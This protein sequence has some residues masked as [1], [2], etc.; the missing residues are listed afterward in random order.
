MASRVGSSGCGAQVKKALRTP[1]SSA[2]A[3][4]Q[5]QVVCYERNASYISA[6]TTAIFSTKISD[7]LAEADF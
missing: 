7:Q 1:N 2:S 5:G 3:K 6:G 4:S